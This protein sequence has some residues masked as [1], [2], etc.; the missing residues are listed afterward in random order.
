MVFR[1]ILDFGI[2]LQL[3]DRNYCLIFHSTKT[4]HKYIRNV[5]RLSLKINSQESFSPQTT[6]VGKLQH[7]IAINCIPAVPTAFV[8]TQ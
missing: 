5:G 8:T 3:P 2:D 1:R 7:C 4:K 6:A